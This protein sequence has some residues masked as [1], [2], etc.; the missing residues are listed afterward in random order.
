MYHH[1]EGS[2]FKHKHIRSKHQ[3]I[4]RRNRNDSK[5]F[6]AFYF[7]TAKKIQKSRINDIFSILSR[8]QS[9]SQATSKDRKD[10]DRKDRKDRYDRKDKKDRKDR[11]DKKDKKDKKDRKTTYE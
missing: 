8:P 5:S 10:R 4:V 9:I 3:K 6:W 2:I 11:K 1:L 7:R